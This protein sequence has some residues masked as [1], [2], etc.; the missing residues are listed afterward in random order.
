VSSNDQWKPL[1]RKFDEVD[2]VLVPPGCFMMGTDSVGS[3]DY[4]ANKQCFAMPFWIDRYEVSNAEFAAFGVRLTRPSAWTGG[5]RPR[6]R[7]YWPEAR[8]FCVTRGARLL[9]E[10]EWEYA[11]RGPDGLN[12]PWGNRFDAN[13]AVYRGNSNDQTADAGSKPGGASWVGAFDMSGNVWE[14]VS[15]LYQPYP[16]S[17]ADGRENGAD[18]TNRRVIRGGGWGDAEGSLS[19]TNRLGIALSFED[20]NIG[21]RCA[22]SF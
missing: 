14:W 2:M 18:E 3:D 13:N 4:P 12:Y 10:A 1:I 11:A 8:N 20:H 21:F 9:T 19:A 15:S 22:R 5:N 6:E 16:Y 17:A 7:V